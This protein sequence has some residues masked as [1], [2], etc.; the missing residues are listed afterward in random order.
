MA[1]DPQIIK[2]L[3]ED[4]DNLNDVIDDISKQ[5]QGNLN[6]QLA[7]TS[8]EINNI[9]DS[10]EKGEDITKKT[11]A[12]LRKAQTENRKLGLDQNRIQT[13]LLEVEKQ[14]AKKYSAKLKAQKDSLAL[15]LQDNQ[16]Q[17]ELNESLID[18]LRT[19]YNVAETEKKNNEERKK[20]R[21][22][23]GY[24]DQQF[25]NIYESASKLFSIAGLFKA[26]IDSGLRF[27]KVSVDLGK[28]LGYG[29]DNANNFTKELVAAAQTSDNLNFTLQN[30]SEAINELNAATG[31]IAE[32]SKDALETQIM[33]T[34]QFGLT[35]DEAAGIY[36]LSL[37]TGKSAEKVND[38]MVGAFVAARNQLGKAVPFKATIAEAAKVSG[39]LASNLQNSPPAI[40]KAVVATKALGT[41]LEQTAKQGEALLNFESSIESELKAELLTGKQL[42]LERARA[43]A[44]A[45]DQVTAAQ[46]LFSQVGSLAEFDRMNVLQKKAIAEAVGLT[47]D[48]LADQLR[49]Q[50]IAQEQGKSLAQITKEEALEAER[51]QAIQDKFNQAI[52]KLQDLIGN[53]VAGPMGFFI[54]SLSK[55]LD[56]IGKIFGKIGKVGEAIKSIPGMEYIGKIV[57]GIASM[58]TVGALIGLVARSL[59]KG[60]YINPMITKDFSVA[61]G[62]RGGGGFFGGGGGSG[63]AGNAALKAAQAKGLSNKQIAAGF[64]GKAA[65]GALA[66]GTSLAG[67]KGL[68]KGL[69]KVAKG[70]ALTALAFG[71]IEAASNLSEGKGA[72]ES[73]GRALITGLFSLGG[74]ALG[75]LLGPVGTIGGGIGGGLL[76]GE[77]GDMIFGKADDMAGYGARTLVTPKGPIAL[78]N[79]DTVIAGT[80]LFKGDDV[81]SFP[82]G[83][84]NLSGGVDLA[85]MIAALNEVKTAITGITNRPIKLYVD[86]TEIIT[87]MEKSATRTS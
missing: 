10:L 8:T 28:N 34:K 86:G 41:S 49:K 17:Q 68:L 73:I 46:E 67:G 82:K 87:K 50:K 72:G 66:S 3:S 31:Y 44:L 12:A 26:I 64:G 84:L 45:G 52:L 2:K 15:Q 16:L 55:G 54:E 51:R 18:Y 13:Q 81:T 76:G 53:L 20:Q 85:P 83:A 19:L 5:I 4:L 80:N 70:N 27:N 21:T 63:K 48:E 79:Q 61:G 30:A 42:N 32:Y 58:A 59:L 39:I 71:G 40:V 65:K 69:G 56:L 33:L 37:L 47:A 29:V 23:L 6:K 60:T 78:N 74:G 77:V 14:L 24:L 36:K 43:A 22:L 62:G 57:G 11:S 25:K 7:V 1:T 38:E 35:G 9:V 75:S